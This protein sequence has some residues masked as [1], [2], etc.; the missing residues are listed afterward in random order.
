MINQLILQGRL[1]RDPELRTTQSG[2]A[3]TSFTVAWSEKYKETETK[4]FL[5]CTAW[6]GTAEFVEKYFKKGQEILVRGKLSTRDWQDKEGNNRQST[7]LTA[8]EVT[9]C[10]PKQ[11]GGTFNTSYDTAAT[12]SDVESD[13]E[14]PF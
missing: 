4:L 9:F 12:F 1:T 11:D 7:E 13:E 6:R 10:G 5:N 3:V 2:V 8:D 14:L